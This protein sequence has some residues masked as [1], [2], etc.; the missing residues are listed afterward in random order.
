ME[1]RLLGKAYRG[2]VVTAL[3]VAVLAGCGSGPRA[4]LSHGRD[5]FKTCEPCHGADG[6]GN[7][8][9]RAPT[10]AGLPEWYVATELGKFQKNIRG[11]HPDDEEGARMRP[12]A[13]TLYHPGDLQAVA[14]YV[15]R[16]PRVK[17]EPMMKGD[18]VAG[19]K[20]YTA[21]CVACHG[22][23]GKGNQ[24]MNAPP[25]PQQADWYL[26]A[27]LEKFKT[28]MRGA[29]ALDVEG[30]QMKAMSA[31]LLDSTAMHDVVAYIKSMPN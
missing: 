16:L 1:A 29:T 19:Q 4:S 7:V 14:A 8:A 31:T 23:D 3:L 24:A 27:Q 11:A 28:G 6:A 30:S 15:A 25:L 22:P 10:I 2:L 18:P 5:V 26:V 9:L 13:R 17:V 20:H 21:I 12:M